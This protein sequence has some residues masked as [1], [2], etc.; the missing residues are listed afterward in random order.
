MTTGISSL[1]SLSGRL[2]VYGK[3]FEMVPAIARALSVLVD[4]P[5]IEGEWSL[6]NA[7]E[8]VQ[9]LVKLQTEK[10]GQT[11]LDIRIGWRDGEGM[12]KE[13]KKQTI[14]QVQ[15]RTE[16]VRRFARVV[17]MYEGRF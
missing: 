15:M 13:L 12:C 4:A 5:V 1:H 10:R 7:G 14:A 3:M 11:A 9:T 17:Q 16:S 8:I 6:E 2:Q